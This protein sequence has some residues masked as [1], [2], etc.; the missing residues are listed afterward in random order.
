M[1]WNEHDSR[2]S[3]VKRYDAARTVRLIVTEQQKQ[4]LQSQARNMESM[5]SVL[6]RLIDQAMAAE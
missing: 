6:R 2:G 1:A 4:W 5:S 3:S